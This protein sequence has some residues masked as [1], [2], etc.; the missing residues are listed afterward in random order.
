MKIRKFLSDL[1]VPDEVRE[2][3]HSIPKPVGSFG[4]DPWGYNEEGAAIGLSMVKWLYDNYFRV[5]TTGLENI[6]AEGRVLVIANHSGQLPMDGMLIGTALAMNPNGPRAPRA[7]IE[8]FFPTMPFVGNVLNMFG[9]VIGDPVNCSKMLDAEEAI[10]VFPEGIRGSG[11]MYRDRYQLKRFGN[12]FMHLAINHNTPIIPVG[13]VGCEET[14]PAIAN[15]APLAKML[16]VPYVPVAPP[17]PLP[18]RVFLNF[19]E[20][21]RFDVDVDSEDAVTAKVEEV[22]DAIRGLIRVGLKQRGDQIF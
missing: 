16:G 8:R 14:M 6:P 17:V 13:V 3:I 22:K 18:A 11:K 1:I 10:I 5:Q 21:M 15:I 2:Q 7:M 9:A 19:G 12:G 4:W 20:P